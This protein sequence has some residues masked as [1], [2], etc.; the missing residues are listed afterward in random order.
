MLN[1]FVPLIHNLL[2]GA[3]NLTLPDAEN[4]KNRRF[5]IR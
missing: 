1:V 3:I 2:L 4:A 5:K